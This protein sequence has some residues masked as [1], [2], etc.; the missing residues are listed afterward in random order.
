MLPLNMVL[1]MIYFLLSV[2]Y[3]LKKTSFYTC[4]KIV[5]MSSM[6]NCKHK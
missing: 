6:A 3:I 4:V 1:S 5:F 2:S